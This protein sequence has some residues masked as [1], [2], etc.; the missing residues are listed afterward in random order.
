MSDRVMR[1][2]AFGRS[3]LLVAIGLAAGCASGPL[4]ARPEVVNPSQGDEGRDEITLTF[5]VSD[6]DLTPASVRVEFND[7]T[8]W[9]PATNP[10]RSAT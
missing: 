2:R 10:F 4:G 7:A 1:T 9:M 3:A 5:Q 8:G 6:E